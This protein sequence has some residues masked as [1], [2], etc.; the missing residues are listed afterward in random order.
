MLNCLLGVGEAEIVGIATKSKS[1][2]NVD[3]SDLSDIAIKEKIPYK[4]VRDINQSHI[5]DWIKSLKPEVIFCFGWSSLI[6]REL[7][8]LCQLGVIGFHPAKLPQN[9]GRHPLIWAL[10]LGLKESATTFFKMDEGADSGDILS[11][12]TFTIEEE[13][14]AAD[15]YLKMIDN[16]SKQVKN[17]VPL[18]ASGDFE[19]YRQD[20]S[21]AN[22]WRK[23]GKA[24]GKIDFRMQTQSIY[25]LVRA[26]SKPYIGAH[27]DYEGHEYKVWQVLPG[28]KKESNIEPGKVLDIDDRHCILVKTSDSSIWIIDHELSE[29]PNISDYLI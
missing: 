7:L 27:L 29:V 25:N 4:Y 6:K 2:F 12:N 17:F 5:L 8:E 22:E 1:Q 24:D 23:R 16:A 10:V 9:R 19:L 15:L 3:H 13:D 14:T 20:H 26:L 21:Q 11:Q 28:P 18:L